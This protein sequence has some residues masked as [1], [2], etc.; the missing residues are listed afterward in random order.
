MDLFLQYMEA[1]AKE[2]VSK[3]KKLLPELETH[4]RAKDRAEQ[5]K[6]AGHGK[7]RGADVSIEELDRQITEDLKLLKLFA[8]AD[9]KSLCRHHGIDPNGTKPTLKARLLDFYA[10]KRE[11]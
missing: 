11:Q 4:R 2:D 1:L 6:Q 3:A 5:E 9:L 10:A 7:K 8:A